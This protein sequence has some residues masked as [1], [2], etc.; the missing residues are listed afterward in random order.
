MFR[1]YLGGVSILD[2][3]IGIRQIEWIIPLEI[4][5]FDDEPQRGADRGDVFVHDLLDDSGFARVV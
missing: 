3:I 4:Y 5:G 1:R 2:E